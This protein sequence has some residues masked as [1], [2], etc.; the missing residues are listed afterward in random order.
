MCTFGKIT[1]AKR[2]NNLV[3]YLHF[4]LLRVHLFSNNLK[5]SNVSTVGFRF[6]YL[7]I[8]WNAIIND[9]CCISQS[10]NYLKKLNESKYL[11]RININTVVDTI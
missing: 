3:I 2:R 4:H 11:Q 8:I 1:D 6:L 7:V 9:I 5:P 10:T